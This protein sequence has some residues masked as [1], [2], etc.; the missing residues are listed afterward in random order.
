[1]HYLLMTIV[2]VTTVAAFEA[3]GSIIVIAML[4]VPPAT[5]LLLTSRLLIVI[6]LA[7]AADFAARLVLQP[8]L[9]RLVSRYVG[10]ATP[11]T[12]RVAV[13]PLGLVV[14]AVA[15]L[16]LVNLLGLPGLALTIAVVAARLLLVVGGTWSAWAATDLVANAYVRR[17]EGGK[18]A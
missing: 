9:S 8:A 6:F 14:A 16:L 5:A 4:I 11:D 7:V 18:S 12:V 17:P 3:V 2:A 15:F 13:R 1:M 10:E